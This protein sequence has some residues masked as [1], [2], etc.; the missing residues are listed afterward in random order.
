MGKKKD[1]PKPRLYPTDTVSHLTDELVGDLDIPGLPDSIPSRLTDAVG[2]RAEAYLYALK[3][4]TQQRYI[5]ALEVRLL[6]DA[7]RVV[8]TA[9]ELG[10]PD[11]P[12]YYARF[13]ALAEQLGYERTEVGFK[14]GED[15]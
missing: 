8:L 2:R 9:Y 4:A 12:V 14:R 1:K 3:E 13:R 7:H 11:G 15:E 6:R 5:T 10:L